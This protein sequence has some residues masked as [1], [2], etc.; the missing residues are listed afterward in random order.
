MTEKY[1]LPIAAEVDWGRQWDV[2]GVAQRRFHI[3]G[4]L[5]KSSHRPLSSRAILSHP[6]HCFS[7]NSRV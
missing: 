6:C 5:F 1:L 2:A 4:A 3:D 7:V